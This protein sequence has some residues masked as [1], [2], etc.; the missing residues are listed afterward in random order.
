V[1]F[2]RSWRGISWRSREGK[3]HPRDHEVI[4]VHHYTEALGPT[5][6]PTWAAALHHAGYQVDDPGLQAVWRVAAEAGAV[7]GGHHP[8]LLAGGAA[9]ELAQ[10]PARDLHFFLDMM[11]WIRDGHWPCGWDE[12]RQQ[13][14]VF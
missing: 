2:L 9:G 10:M 4:R 3:P 11:P 13:L 5:K 6:S 7:T 12:A 14:K 8:A 1:L